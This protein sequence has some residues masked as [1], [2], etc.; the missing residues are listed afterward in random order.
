MPKTNPKSKPPDFPSPRAKSTSALHDREVS[1][2]VSQPVPIGDGAIVIYQSCI[3]RHKELKLLHPT[4]GVTLA[5]IKNIPG[6][7]CTCRDR[8]LV[9]NLR[10]LQQPRLANQLRVA[11]LVGACAFQQG[12]VAWN[13]VGA[14]F[15]AVEANLVAQP[16]RPL[17]EG[18]VAGAFLHGY[19]LLLTPSRLMVFDRS[20]RLMSET[21][22]PSRSLK[23]LCGCGGSQLVS[24]GKTVYRVEIS[25]Q[26]DIVS[27]TRHVVKEHSG[28]SDPNLLFSR[29]DEVYLET[30]HGSGVVTALL[31]GGKVSNT[32]SYSQHPWFYRTA[33]LGRFLARLAADGETIIL[34]ELL[35]PVAL[36][37]HQLTP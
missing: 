16:P 26:G 6:L 33:K 20:L 31:P 32:T 36:K 23:Y 28:I 18:V 22:F 1:E 4:V 14:V 37:A 13:A 30:Q 21:D 35:P 19:L 5:S 17:V 10:R 8:L 2:L 7:L 27:Q 11:D 25:S 3:V 34:E 15:Y 12:I 24:D 29:N 9:Y